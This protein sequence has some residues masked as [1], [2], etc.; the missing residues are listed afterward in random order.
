MMAMG[1]KGKE[2][3]ETA[4]IYELKSTYNLGPEVLDKQSINLDGVACRRPLGAGIWFAVRHAYPYN[5]G[6]LQYASA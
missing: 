4:S 5:I 3:D 1:V 2:Q 6:F